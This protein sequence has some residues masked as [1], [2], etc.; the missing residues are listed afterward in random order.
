MPLPFLQ[1]LLHRVRARN[2]LPLAQA[3]DALR[4]E[5][6]GK[7][8]ADNFDTLQGIRLLEDI[9]ATDSIDTLCGLYNRLAHIE[10]REERARR[11]GR[12][13]EVLHLAPGPVPAAA[14]PAA[15]PAFALAG[16][17]GLD[18]EGVEVEIKQRLGRKYHRFVSQ[19]V[20]DME[21]GRGKP[22][23]G[24]RG[25]WHV[26]AG[27]PGVGSCSVFYYLEGSREKIRVVGIGRHVGRAAYQLDY[28]AEDLG[29]A[30]RILRIA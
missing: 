17:T 6:L 7:L 8:R 3:Q 1:R 2:Y 30:G 16:K 14:D 13:Q 20:N 11:Q 15:A 19:A 5:V 9:N 24:Y 22:T 12:R 26:S 21:F 23:S 29:E 25:L 10:R 28:A 18:A 4:Q 27:I